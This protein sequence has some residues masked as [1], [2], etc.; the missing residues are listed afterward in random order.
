[1]A[2]TDWTNHIGTV[3]GIV[4]ATLG[5]I[6]FFR[7]GRYKKQDLRIQLRT[8][9][10]ELWMII[11]Q[12]E[13]TLPRAFKSRE[14]TAAAQKELVSGKMEKWKTQ[15]AKDIKIIE[16]IEGKAPARGDRFKKLSEDETEDLFVEVDSF[17]T[18][19][20]PLLKKYHESLEQDKKIGESIMERAIKRHENKS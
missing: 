2:E 16:D 7:T 3:T 6:S 1:M 20:R 15:Y 8:S 17:K 9:T 12:S 18:T 13:E 19:L 10:R 5:L 11:S 14:Q 4:G